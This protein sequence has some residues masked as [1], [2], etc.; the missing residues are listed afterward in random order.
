MSKTTKLKKIVAREG[1]VILAF[2]FF[3]G[4]SVFLFWKCLESNYDRY[5]LAYDSHWALGFLILIFGYP[6]YL[7]I[8]FIIWAHRTLKE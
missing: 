2:L 5:G 6:L 8:K 3:A 7:L 1:L 4:I